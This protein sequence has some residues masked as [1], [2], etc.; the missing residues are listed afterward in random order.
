MRLD[1]FLK[2]SRLAPRRTVA[3][4]LCDAGL[5]MVNGRAAKPAHAVKPGDELTLRLRDRQTTVRILSVPTR[6][7][8]SRRDAS[9]LIE[10]LEEKELDAEFGFTPATLSR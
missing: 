6:R 2:L 7:S 4:K 8:V 5:V 1:L 10:V 9:E 3:Q